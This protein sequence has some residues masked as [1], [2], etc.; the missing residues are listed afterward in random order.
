MISALLF[1]AAI[2]SLG[3]AVEPDRL[4]FGPFELANPNREARL[5]V[6]CDETP[7]LRAAVRSL[8]E[9]VERKTGVKMKYS[10]Y[11]S[12]M[13]GDVFVSTQPWAAKGAWF[14]RL[15]NN[16]VAIHGS[17]P[18]ATLKAL[19]AGATVY[20][21]GYVRYDLG[22]VLGDPSLA[23]EMYGGNPRAS[24]AERHATWVRDGDWQMKPHKIKGSLL[25][26]TT[27]MYPKCGKGDG[28]T[29]LAKMK[30]ADGAERPFLSARRVG[31]GVLILAGGEM[32][33]PALQLMENVR[34]LFDQTEG[35]LK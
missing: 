3:A 32:D 35:E 5:M 34:G 4:D 25:H 1:A 22:Q 13:G 28:W 29:V 9:L 18:A 26:G 12:P 17:D 8:A 21:A 16:I 15:K 33:I 10:S 23:S 20:F 14:V 30:A 19:K 2:V 24:L 11:S 31:K 6:G 7:E 27:P